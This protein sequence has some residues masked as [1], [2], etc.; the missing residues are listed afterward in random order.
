MCSPSRGRC[1]RSMYLGVHAVPAATAVAFLKRHVRPSSRSPCSHLV[2]QYHRHGTRVLV[3]K[4][5]RRGIRRLI[6]TRV[7]SRV[8]LCLIESH[9]Y[10]AL[11]AFRYFV[12]LCFPRAHFA[13]TRASITARA[14]HVK[15]TRVFCCL[16]APQ[17]LYVIRNQCI[18]LLSLGGRLWVGAI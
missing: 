16:Q 17:V 5:N 8:L 15:V 13:V 10:E 4:I 11:R 1:D 12:D 6:Q 9:L 14:S 7:I 3:C 18:A 2:S